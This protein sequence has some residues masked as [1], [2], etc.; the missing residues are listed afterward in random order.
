MIDVSVI[1]PTRER[2][3]QLKKALQSVYRQN[4]CS[5]ECFVVDDGPPEKS[6]EIRSIVSESGARYETTGGSRGGSVARN[7]GIEHAGGNYIAFLDDDDWWADDKLE[8]QLTYLRSNDAEICYTGITIVTS[9]GKKRYSFRLPHEEDQY[10]SIMR[11]NFIGGTSSVMVKREA[12]EA[13]HG[14]DPRLPALQDYDLYIRLLRRFRTGWINAPLTT[15]FD[16]NH[17]SKVS[18][19]RERFLE[20]VEL[21]KQKYRDDF[22]Y[23]LLQKSFRSILLLKC[24]RSR[25]FF[26]ETVRAFFSDNR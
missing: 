6:S 20:A 21:L 23:P 3:D 24:F 5:L 25:H 16:D 22:C 15:Y 2:P 10:R 19:S 8:R 12:I 17:D 13:V 4:G 26:L 18:A 1:I 9:R 14:F 7:I 11:K